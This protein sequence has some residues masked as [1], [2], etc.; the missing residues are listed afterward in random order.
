VIERGASKGKWVARVADHHDRFGELGF[1]LL[2]LT[3]LRVQQ[4]SGAL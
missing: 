3:T 2:K 4:P 1:G